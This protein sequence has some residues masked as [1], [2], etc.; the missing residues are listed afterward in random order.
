LTT[1]IEKTIFSA[2][3]GIFFEMVL[4]NGS[5]GFAVYD[6]DSKTCTF[7]QNYT[8]VVPM[9]TV[10]WKYLAGI[11]TGYSDAFTLYR[12]VRSFI[13]DNVEMPCNDDYEILAAW[14]MAS[15]RFKEFDSFPYLCAIGPKNSGKTHLLKTLCQLSYRGLLGAAMTTS[16]M[17][18]AIERDSVSIFY[19]QAEQFAVNKEES[20]MIAIVNNGYQKGGQKILYN[21]EKECY[22]G[23]DCYS[24]KAFASTM[25]LRGTI[26]SRSIVFNMQRKTRGN[27]SIK[28]DEK[29]A[30][31]LRSKLLLYKFR[32][33]N[34]DNS[35]QSEESEEECAKVTN[36]GR[37]VEL[38]VPLLA[39]TLESSF[40]SLSSLS[41]PSKI[42]IDYM[43]RNNQAREDEEQAS[44]DA[45]IIRA[46]S[47]A[48]LYVAGGKLSYA[49]IAEQFNASKNSEKEKWGIKS[50]A[51]KV[52][53]LGFAPC[54]LTGGIAGIYYDETRLKKHRERFMKEEEKPLKAFLAPIVAH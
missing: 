24:P 13:Y 9:K 19:D 17:F 22:E 41:S 44:I 30:F 18:H 43:K 51:R 31:E 7:V 8:S 6:K 14:V 48:S 20:D 29:K 45:Q 11:S 38:F 27:I 16:A 52:K 2:G 36:D 4:H 25:S 3:D 40:P 28:I 53:D 15:Y 23:F 12:E 49:V 1:A 47:E 21:Q 26:E 39:V 50:V 10:P 42:I 32:N 33:Q 54:R 5:K 34:S 35:E 46:I 37:L